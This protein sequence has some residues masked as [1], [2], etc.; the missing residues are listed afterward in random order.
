M[1]ATVKMGVD[2]FDVFFFWVIWDLG[3]GLAFRSW[4]RLPPALGGLF[5]LLSSCYPHMSFLSLSAI[6]FIRR[7][8]GGTGGGSIYGAVNSSLTW[9]GSELAA[10]FQRGW[11]FKGSS[12]VAVSSLDGLAGVCFSGGWLA[13]ALA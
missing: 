12:G 7:A 13:S 4:Q 3:W 11:A 2:V 1:R 5:Q 9:A 6:Y 8:A 10:P